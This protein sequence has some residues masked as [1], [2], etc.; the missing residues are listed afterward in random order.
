MTAVDQFKIICILAPILTLLVLGL[1]LTLR[2]GIGSLT[3]CQGTRQLVRNL[4][5]TVMM[6]AVCLAG[7]MLVQQ[8]IGVRMSMMW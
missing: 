7:L 8:L 5:K 3:S 1:S 4:S 2:N 6:L